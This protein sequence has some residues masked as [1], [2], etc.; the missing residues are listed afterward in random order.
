[1]S[2]VIAIVIIFCFFS[3][4]VNRIAVQFNNRF[5]SEL[6]GGCAFFSAIPVLASIV[7]CL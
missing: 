3:I 5:L 2:T 6:A 7:F 1:M 4:V